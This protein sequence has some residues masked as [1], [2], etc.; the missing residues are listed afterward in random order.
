[1][2]ITEPIIQLLCIESGGDCCRVAIM[3]HMITEYDEQVLRMRKIYRC[4]CDLLTYM[5]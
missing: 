1:M 5:G 4:K 3:K 2:G